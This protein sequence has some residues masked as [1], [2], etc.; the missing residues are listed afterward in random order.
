LGPQNYVVYLKLGNIRLSEL[1][2]LN[3][4]KIKD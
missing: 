4:T 1:M 2:S 3:P